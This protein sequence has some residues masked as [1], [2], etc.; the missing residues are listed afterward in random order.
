M[1]LAKGFM[2]V[3][4]R[5]PNKE[6]LQKIMFEAAERDMNKAIDSATT[7]IK[8]GSI[9]AIGRRIKE[10][11]QDAL[12]KSIDEFNIPIRTQEPKEELQK[13]I[14]EAAERDL[15]N[16]INSAKPPGL[17]SKDEF[18]MNVGGGSKAIGRRIEEMKK[19]LGLAEG[20]LAGMLGE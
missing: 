3:T 12:R 11:D 10:I 4:G 5:K 8:G 14:R 9:K 1:E 7:S 15:D 19:K 13:T 2:R 6:E 16:A 18:A 20:G 17:M